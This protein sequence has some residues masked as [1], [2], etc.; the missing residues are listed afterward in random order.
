MNLQRAGERVERST[1]VWILLVI[2]QT[3]GEKDLEKKLGRNNNTKID[4]PI[5]G[6]LHRTD[7]V[8]SR[9]VCMVLLCAGKWI[10]R[11]LGKFQENTRKIHA[12]EA[13][14]DQKWGQRGP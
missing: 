7:V 2:N 14:T 10:F 9:A 12:T 5:F 8:F 13:S 11:Y 6:V 3:P 4:N 1:I